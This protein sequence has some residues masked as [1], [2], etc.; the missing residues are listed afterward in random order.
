MTDAAVGRLEALYRELGPSLWAYLRRRSPDAQ[1]ADDLLQETFLQAARRA[2]R[3]REATSA[4]AWLFAIAR[5]LAATARRRRR[6]TRSLT[7]EPP[8]AEAA[9][10]PRLEAVRAALAEL[11]GTLKEALELRLHSQ[12]SY[13]EIAEVLAIPIGTVRSRLHSA[14]RRLREV[15]VSA[16]ERRSRRAA[17]RPDP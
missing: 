6:E 13:A 15:L 4:R 12:L 1:A 17:I 2:E 8:A 10:D 11:P 5:N 14:L 3:L 16:E 7:A 9:E